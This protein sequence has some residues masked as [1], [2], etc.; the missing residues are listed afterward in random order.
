MSLLDT[1]RDHFKDVGFRSRKFVLTVATMLLIFAGG[2]M[3]GVWSL[4]GSHYET[5]ISG[6]LGALGLYLG[7][8]VGSRWATAKHAA[9]LVGG[10]KD[11]DKEVSPEATPPDEDS[12]SKRG[13]R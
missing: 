7:G 13:E 2:V 10:V 6:L 9:A 11:R 12:P 1:I 5:M 8:N 4:F 3:A